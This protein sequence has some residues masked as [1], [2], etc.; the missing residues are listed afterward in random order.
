MGKKTT[1]ADVLTEPLQRAVRESG[2]TFYMLAKRT[3]ISRMSL[4]RF[5]TGERSLRLDKAGRLADYFGL[6]LVKRKG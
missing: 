2:E 6:R 3:G 4:T 1:L 5:A